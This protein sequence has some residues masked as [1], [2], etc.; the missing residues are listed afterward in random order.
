HTQDGVFISG[1]GGAS[2]TKIYDLNGGSTPANQWQNVTIDLDQ[3][4]ASAGV[5]LTST[6]VIRIQQHDNWGITSDGFAIDSV[7]VN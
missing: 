5:G 2:F 1:N 7:T 6:F 4:A 3:A